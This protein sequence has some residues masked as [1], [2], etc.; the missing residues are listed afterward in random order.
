MHI[1]AYIHIYVQMHA[2]PHMNTHTY[3]YIKIS[4]RNCLEQPVCHTSATPELRKTHGNGVSS[5]H[6][7]HRVLQLGRQQALGW[8]GLPAALGL[9]VLSC[10]V[11]LAPLGEGR[12]LAPSGFSRPLLVSIQSALS[13]GPYHLP[14]VLLL[15]DISTTCKA[16]SHLLFPKICFDFSCP[17]FPNNFGNHL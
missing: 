10:F 13:W 2:H 15:F 3:T 16:C 1:H 17:I 7:S 5:A 6:G 14:C 8:A 4:L 11:N 12:C 9:C